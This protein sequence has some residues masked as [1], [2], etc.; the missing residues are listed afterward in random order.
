MR[1]RRVACVIPRFS[2]ILAM[3]LVCAAA[4][5]SGQ[6]ARGLSIAASAGTLT[7]D[8]DFVSGSRQLFGVAASLPLKPFLEIEGELARSGRF[9]RQYDGSSVSFAPPGSPR[10]DVERLSV[11]TRFT[12]RRQSRWLG[13]LGVAFRSPRATRV[14]PRLFLGLTGHQVVDVSETATLRLPPGVTQEEVDRTMPGD[15]PWSRNVGGLT[16]G[17]S[18]RVALGRRIWIAPDAR[19]DYGSIGDE[20]N[21]AVRMTLRAGW[22]F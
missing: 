9:A 4:P 5:A 6:P 14:Q 3:V 22:Q 13:S 8:A 17:G 15:H 19:Y 21:N 10:E 18:V 20:I 1:S 7:M 11:L 16:V 12:H 2:P